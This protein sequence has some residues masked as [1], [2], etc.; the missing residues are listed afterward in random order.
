[1]MPVMK[2][3]TRFFAVVLAGAV[4]AA[5]ALLVACAIA[6]HSP[7]SGSVE[8]LATSGN[9]CHEASAVPGAPYHVRS[10]SRSCG[11][12]HGQ[13]G[14]QPSGVDPGISNKSLHTPIALVTSPI[15]S[16]ARKTASPFALL[17]PPP[18]SRT[19]SSFLLPLR[20]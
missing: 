11:H 15:G 6:C 14:V 20:L 12:D 2:L 10:H 13:T 1:M 4:G 3:V 8:T 7:A 19:G 16:L 17:L 5:P 18:G 9:S